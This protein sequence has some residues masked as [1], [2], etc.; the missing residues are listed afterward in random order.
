M[1][2]Q[3]TCKHIYSLV[4]DHT[5]Y[6]EETLSPLNFHNEKFLFLWKVDMTAKYGSSLCMLSHK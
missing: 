6:F 1:S 5:H 4:L 2:T 3:K